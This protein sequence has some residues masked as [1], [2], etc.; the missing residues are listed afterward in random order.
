VPKVPT[1]TQSEVQLKPTPI[2]P[3]TA[4]T[5]GGEVVDLAEGIGSLADHMQKVQGMTDVR[6]GLTGLNQDAINIHNQ[7][8]QDSDLDNAP[9]KAQDAFQKAVE[10][11][12]N[13]IPDAEA[14]NEFLNKASSVQDRNLTTINSMIEGKRIKAANASMTANG[15][16]FVQTYSHILNNPDQQQQAIDE[17]KSEAYYHGQ[18]VGTPKPLLDAYVNNTIYKA[19]VAEHTFNIDID[20]TAALEKIKNDSDLTAKDRDKLQKEATS[21]ISQNKKSSEELLKVSQDKN[22]NDM[23]I[24]KNYK[25][26]TG[27]QIEEGLWTK[28]INEKQYNSLLKNYL[29]PYK[30]S[31]TTDK[32]EYYNSMT[33]LTDPNV[34][35]QEKAI[36]L[37]D[38]NSDGK[39]SQPDMQHLFQLHILPNKGGDATSLQQDPKVKQ[40]AQLL[41]KAQK[42]DE[43]LQQRS[44]AWF[45][46]FGAIK[47][48]DDDQHNVA[49]LMKNLHNEVS[50]EQSITPEV[51]ESKV[52]GV[53]SKDL[54]NKLVNS[55][56][57][58]DGIDERGMVLSNGLFVFK[59]KDGVLA[60]RTATDQE[61]NQARGEQ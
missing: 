37:L 45:R 33:L 35:T 29:S 26:L 1:L 55:G 58:V 31:A 17:F 30:V 43:Q 10:A 19:K 4:A 38:L 59:K 48:H 7:I 8:Y 12:A 42:N 21:R 34:S 16:S 14:R 44:K 57:N 28:A 51:I 11:R 56:I 36:H 5:L 39:L 13:A 18:M 46:A 41:D 54:H 40:E 22:F 2:N 25:V 49:D 3:K 60:Y 15:D 61:M 6:N 52:Q 24:K 50:K 27:Q 32:N 53:I 20:P 23:A 9:Q 47:N